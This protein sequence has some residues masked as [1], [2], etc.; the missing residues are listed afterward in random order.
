MSHQEITLQNRGWIH[1]TTTQAT[2]TCSW[3]DVDLATDEVRLFRQVGGGAIVDVTTIGIGR[4]PVGLARVSE[5]S[6]VPIVMGA[7]FYVD[8]VHPED[9][10][11]P[12]R[13]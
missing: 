2:S 13:G 5:G 4:D 1:Y 12:L 6:G 7:G 9:M 11:S 3:D 10:D 8:M